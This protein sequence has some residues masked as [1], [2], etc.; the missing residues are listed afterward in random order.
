L[1]L[2]AY[3]R[4]GY[5]GSRDRG[6]IEFENH[7]DDLISLARREAVKGPV[8]YFGHSFG[9]VVAFG[10]ALR[11]PSLTQQVI[12]YETPLPWVRY[13]EGSRATLSANPEE[14]AE[15]FFRRMVSNGAWERL[16][17]FEQQSRRLDGPALYSDMALFR[18]GAKPF[19]LS[20]LEVPSLYTHGDTYHIEYYRALCR[21]LHALNPII[22]SRELNKAGHGAHLSHPDHL[23]DL[24]LDT[25]AQRCASQ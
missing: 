13:R 10:A 9:G 12:V 21:D 5:Q 23:A 2:V 14:E 6:P 17:E 11:E 18:S 8:L 20:Q 7:L 25:W 24:I 22:T 16:S 15:L 19:D 4:R 3:D 1:D